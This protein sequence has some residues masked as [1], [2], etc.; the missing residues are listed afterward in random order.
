MTPKPSADQEPHQEAGENRH[1]GGGT[2]H[3]GE[4][5]DGG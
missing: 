1:G 5:D 3:A 2:E 4:F